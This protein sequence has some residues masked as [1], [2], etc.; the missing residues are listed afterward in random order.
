LRHTLP[1]NAEAVRLSVPL[2]PT[3]R[4]S[5]MNPQNQPNKDRHHARLNR[6]CHGAAP[7]RYPT[8]RCNSL[9]GGTGAWNALLEMEDSGALSPEEFRAMS[10]TGGQLN[11]DWVEWLML[12]PVGWTDPDLPEPIRWM[13]SST[14]P[15]DLAEDDPGYIPR[16]TS[17]RQYRAPRIKMEGNG[18]VPLCAAVA[19]EEGLWSLDFAAEAA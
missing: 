10:S 5:D 7:L 19:L 16:V 14:D 12:W 15:A 6:Y 2:F 13:D 1:L 11:P 18:Q 4:A 9:C 17:R 8:P 3:P